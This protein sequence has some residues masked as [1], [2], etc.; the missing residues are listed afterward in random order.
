[1]VFVLISYRM[2]NQSY[3]SNV[4]SLSEAMLKYSTTVE[5]DEAVVRELV[6]T[7]TGNG[8]CLDFHPCYCVVDF[9]AAP[10]QA[11]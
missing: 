8:N 3:Q 6:E 10:T 1:M 7:K 4:Y 9:S 11:R 2:V 5:G